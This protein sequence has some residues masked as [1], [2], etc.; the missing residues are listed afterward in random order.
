MK[1]FS[2]T[3][4]LSRFRDVV[5]PA[6]RKWAGE[7]ADKLEFVKDQV[8]DVE[9]KT[10]D[11]ADN[12]DPEVSVVLPDEFVQD[13]DSHNAFE[14]ALKNATDAMQKMVE[15]VTKLVNEFSEGVNKKLDALM[16]KMEVEISEE[17]DAGEPSDES[18]SDDSDEANDEKDKD[19]PSNDE[20]K[21]DDEPD[22]DDGEPDDVD[23]ALDGV[24][25]L[26]ADVK[27]KKAAGKS[28]A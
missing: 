19:A 27:T 16:M 18:D 24:Y 5:I 20:D 9:R 13:E 26:S 17:D 21:K 10:N 14:G 7:D 11:T 23:K 28:I 6:L 2:R 3:M 1:V 15:D 22:E 8:E 12:E 4:K 25:D